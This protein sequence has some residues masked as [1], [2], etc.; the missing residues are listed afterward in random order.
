M[1][2]RQARLLVGAVFVGASAGL[3]SAGFLWTLAHVTA[4]HQ[5]HQWLVWLLPAAG[6]VVA[7][8]YHHR[9]GSATGGVRLTMTEIDDLREGV[10]LRMAPLVLG[11]T[12]VTHLFGGSAGREGTALQMSTSLTDGVAR[13]LGL[14]VH[15]RRLLLVVALAAG[16]ASV[17]GVPAAGIVF[18]MEVAPTTRSN[19]VVALPASI[20]AALLGDRVVGWG[21]VTH[22]HYA[23][24]GRVQPADLGRAAVAG[25]AFGLCARAF[26]GCTEGVRSIMARWVSSPPLRTLAGG[27]AVVGLTVAVQTHQY[28]GLSLPLLDRALGPAQVV[29]FAFALKLL[30]TSVTVGS[31]YQGGEVTPLFVVGA[32]LGAA[33]GHGFGAS[34]SILAAVGM[35]AVFGSAANASLAC[36]VMGIELF[37]WGLVWPLVIGC[38]V[39][40]LF[41]SRRHLYEVLPRTVVDAP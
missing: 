18:A 21:G 26:L 11:G 35:V 39:A 9:G 5:G 16:F 15:E 2:T 29:W 1:A 10:P 6:M 33:I 7:L 13:R 20:V 32:A 31:G 37:G 38:L 17:F 28:N 3:A 41:S 34:S 24:L 27:I 23:Y 36:I 22:H 14:H 25:I 40:R 30:F 8:V 19:R 12:L 4:I